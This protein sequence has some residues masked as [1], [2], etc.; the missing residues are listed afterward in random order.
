MQLQ[1]QWQHSKEKNKGNRKRNCS[2][3]YFLCLIQICN[4]MHIW[5]RDLHKDNGRVHSGDEIVFP[6]PSEW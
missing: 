1:H 2:K 3:L 4:Y 6:C 5:P